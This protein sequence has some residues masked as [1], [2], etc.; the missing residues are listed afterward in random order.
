[1]RIERDVA[2]A[3]CVVVAL[4]TACGGGTPSAQ[5]TAAASMKSTAFVVRPGAPPPSLPPLPPGWAWPFDPNAAFRHVLPALTVFRPANVDALRAHRLN[6]PQQCGPVEVAPNVWITPLCGH[7]GIGRAAR[8]RRSAM[9]LAPTAPMA[10]T[11]PS[12]PGVTPDSYDLRPLGL[13]GPIKHQQSA[14]VCWSFAFSNVMENALR[15]AG[16]SEDVAP[17][18]LIVHDDWHAVQENG[19]G[20][21]TTLEPTWPYDPHKACKLNR[22]LGPDESCETAYGIRRGSYREDPELAAEAQRMESAGAYRIV[23]IK[24]LAD[25][26]G[27]PD[28]VAA[29][30]AGGQAVY[31]ELEFNARAWS[32]PSSGRMNTLPDWEPDGVGG[33]AV[34]IVAYTNA[35]G[36]RWFLLHN[37][38]GPTWGEDGYAWISSEMV[39]ARLVDAWTVILAD[40]QGRVVTPN[41]GSRPPPPPPPPPPPS[42]QTQ[43][44]TFCRL[45]ALVNRPP[46][47][48]RNLPVGE[49][50][51]T[52]SDPSGGGANTWLAYCRR[53]S[54]GAANCA[55][56]IHGGTQCASAVING[57]SLAACCPAGVNDPLDPRCSTADR[58]APPNAGD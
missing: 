33:H 50:I 43:G 54:S 25:T 36:R 9:T 8:G 34:T 57:K 7:L 2:V 11:P 20:H 37:S 55:S 26:P 35:N 17:L 19:S 30:I 53:A 27:N 16:R 41:G 40:A 1:V 13:D 32:M 42:P 58:F 45:A 38:W 15:R 51:C 23:S 12:A 24:S 4:L 52:S 47:E 14:P 46:M 48:Q 39:R 18:S 49:S 29:T 22:A 5:S 21:A 3:T 6:A 44:R 56:G 28:E 31:A 10:P